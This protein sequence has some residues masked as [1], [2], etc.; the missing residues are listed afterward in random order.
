MTAARQ[1]FE[2]VAAELKSLLKPGEVY[3][4]A[5]KGEDSDF[6]RFNKSEVRQAG[7]VQQRSVT[8]DLISG[9]RH[10]AGDITLAGDKELDRPRLKRL[11]DDLRETVSH[12]PEDPYLLYATDVRSS[13]RQAT[14]KVPDGVT[15]VAAVRDAG[16]GRDL[17]GVWASGGIHTGFAN[18]LGQRNWYSTSSFNLNWSFYHQKDKAVKTGYAG[19]DWDQAAFER[20]VERARQQLDAV[21]RPPRKVDRGGYRVFL[22]PSALQELVGMLCW[23]G[24]GLKAH[25][26]KQTPLLKLVEGEAAMA[27]GVSISE[28]T[29]QGVAPD[30]E[31]SG[32]IR[33]ARVDLI[34]DGKYAECLVS[35]RSAKE[36]DVP[37]NGASE[38]ESPESIEM[39]GGTLPEADA[40]KRL[41]TG[42]W[43]GNLWYLNYSDRS[44]C[45]TTGMT[46]FAT[47]WVEGGEVKAPLDVMRFDETIY[48][49]LGE[50]L[51]GLTAERE[52]LLDDN[53]YFRRSTSSA[54]LPGALIE[55]FQFTL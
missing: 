53:T 12:V 18:S 17:V 48:R 2:D 52:M 25:R 41:G 3:T 28:N 27:K 16:K 38:G 15:A 50:N 26:T 31:E 14:N 21:S 55:D 29:A 22:T 19:F 42:V 10:A 11:M 24:F 37:T 47:F 5:F 7:S 13:E 23:G 30:F 20:K 36:Y 39:A 51:V 49:A 34:K 40:L 45:R 1:Q 54:R 4:C 46:R 32:F 9:K 8:V 44:A 6:V 35:P 33:P 43:I